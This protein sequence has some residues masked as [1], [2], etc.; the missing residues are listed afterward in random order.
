MFFRLYNLTP[1]IATCMLSLPFLISGC[2]SIR[3]ISHNAPVIAQTEPS[4]K[5]ELK[6]P[7]ETVSTETT[8]PR[9]AEPEPIQILGGVKNPGNIPY[10][11]G[12]DLTFYLSQAGAPDS[13]EDS[14]KVQ[15]IRGAPGKKEAQVFDL[16]KGA[17]PSIQGG[18][19]VIVH[20]PKKT[21]IEKSLAVA[22]SAAAIL[23]TAALL[24]LVV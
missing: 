4:S 16:H 21:F 7:V 22:A 17:L 19:I 18:D 2:A 1:A 15:I 9:K 20:P 8:S 24:I 10:R 13:D 11:E 5:K 3:S 14:A 12:A 23:G 6:I